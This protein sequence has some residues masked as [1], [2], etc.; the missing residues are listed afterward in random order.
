MFNVDLQAIETI[1][2]ILTGIYGYL[3]VLKRGNSGREVRGVGTQGETPRCATSGKHRTY[4]DI[5]RERP[6]LILII[7]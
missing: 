2:M 3:N 6:K 4:L 5:V 1:N 7:P